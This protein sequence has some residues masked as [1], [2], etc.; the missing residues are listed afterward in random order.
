MEPI[1]H[2]LGGNGE[3]YPFVKDYLSVIILFCVC[4]MTGYAL[5]IY[6]K[7][8]GNPVYPTICV[9]IG[10]VVNLFLDWLFVVI[11]HWGIKGAAF[12]TGISQVTTTSLLFYYIFFKTNRVKFTK[13]KY[14]IF[15]LFK[16]MKV[17]FAEFLAEISIGIS[18][19]TFNLVILKELGDRGVSSFG[20]IGYISSIITMTMIGFNQGVQPVLSFNLGAKENKKIIKIIKLS[21]LILGGL[22]LFFYILINLFSFEIVSVFLNDIQDI[23]LTQQAL[24]L[25]SFAYIICGYNIFTA[26][27]F[28]AMNQVKI[29]T[30]ITM[31]RGV[32]LLVVFIFVLPKF[33]GAKGIW[34]TVFFTEMVTLLFSYFF[35]K[36]YNPLH[37]Y[38]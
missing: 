21:F 30:I 10:G 12:A 22:G 27:Y 25:Y 1:I 28:T 33:L 23:K 34:L 20:I 13:I 3:L 38:L 6:I 4:Y 8:D 16:I 18:T 14:S 24:V 35:M 5:E 2:F 7:V 37:K 32:I 17:G 29:S 19:F 9:I 15:N 36:K 31:L 26:G 11:F